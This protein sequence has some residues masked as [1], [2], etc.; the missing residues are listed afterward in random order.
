MKILPQILKPRAAFTLIELLVVIAII[1][2]LASLLMPVLGRSKE[3]AK[4]LA[5]INNLKQLGVAVRLYS[6][7]N[8]GKLPN[9]ESLPSAPTSTPPLPRICDL[10]AP[11]L[12]Y[13]TNSLPQNSTVLRCPMDTV[14]RFE[15]NGA[16]YEWNAHYN[17][18]PVDSPR[19]S[20]RPLSEAF[21][22][23]DYELFHDKNLSMNVLFADY[24]VENLKKNEPTID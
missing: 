1:A 17:D 14:G 24:H 19:F 8:E 5:C 7:A 13:N 22:M 2:I 23:Y 12:G 10:L 16:S 3:K 9:A 15:A 6:D 18:R 11:E 20:Q 4:G 21:L